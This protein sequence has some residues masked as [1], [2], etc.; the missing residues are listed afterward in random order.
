MDAHLRVLLDWSNRRREEKVD[1]E[2]IYV[3]WAKVKSSNRQQPLPEAHTTDVLAL[4][5]QVRAGV[6]THLYLTD[7]RSLY[8]ANVG[9]VTADDI[10]EDSGERAHAPAYYEDLAADYWFRLWDI[11]LL[12]SDDTLETIHLLHNLRNVHYADRPVSLYGGVRELPIVVREDPPRT[13]FEDGDLLTGGKLWAEHDAELRGETA[14]LARDLR[15]NLSLGRSGPCWSR[16]AAPSSPAPRLCSG[17]GGTTLPLALRALR[18]S[19]PRRWR[20]S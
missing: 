20:S 6:D 4:D 17:P 16:E 10:L 11:R 14:R 18:S 13:W 8:V 15:D 9:E 12:V 19:T 7:Y 3:W 1:E 2:D 5:E